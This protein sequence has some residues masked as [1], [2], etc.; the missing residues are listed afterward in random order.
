MFLR[1]NPSDFLKTESATATPAR[2]L[3]NIKIRESVFTTNTRIY[4]KNDKIQHIFQHF[5]TFYK[6]FHKR[7]VSIVVKNL[8][9]GGASWPIP[10]LLLLNAAYDDG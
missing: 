6:L 2:T 10:H 8:T 1:Q 7:V 9:G 3:I 4:H 5:M